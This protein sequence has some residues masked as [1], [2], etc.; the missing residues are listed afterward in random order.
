MS[1]DLIEVSRWMAYLAFGERGERGDRKVG[2]SCHFTCLEEANHGL[3][4]SYEA[5]IQSFWSRLALPVWLSEQSEFSLEKPTIL[6]RAH[7]HKSTSCEASPM[8]LN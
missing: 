1:E 4:S 2:S 6:E 5:E 8:V 3:Q 7:G